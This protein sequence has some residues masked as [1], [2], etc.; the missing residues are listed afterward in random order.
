M[1]THTASR[2]TPGANVRGTTLG[3]EISDFLIEFSIGVHR[4]SMYPLDHPS[5]VP[6]AGNVLERLRPMLDQRAQVSLGVAKRQLII[7]G[8]ATTDR[9]PVLTDLA[10]RLHSHQ[11]GA[12]TF[13][14]D[15]TLAGMEGLLRALA[16]DTDQDGDPIGL[17]PKSRIP[18]WP[19]VKLIPVGYEDL[20]LVGS[21]EGPQESRG[22][23]MRLWLGLAQAA[24]ANADEPQDSGTPPGGDEVAERINRRKQE[25]AYD[26]V[27]VGYLL[28]LSDQLARAELDAAASVRG[29]VSK[30]IAALDDEALERILE[31]GGDLAQRRRFVEN[32]TKGLDT[33]AALRILTSASEAA[34]QGISGQMVRLLSKLARQ[35]REGTPPVRPVASRDFDQKVGEL[36]SDWSLDSPNP[37]AY[38]RILD[39]LS[40]ES[41]LLEPRDEHTRR[42]AL[43]LVEMAL[44]VDAYGP[45]I[46]SALDELLA[47]G[48]FVQ[49]V[50][51]IEGAHVTRTGRKIKERLSDP[52]QVERLAELTELHPTSLE[53][54]IGLVGAERAIEPLLIVLAE[55]ESRGTRRTVFDGLAG[56]GEPVARHLQPL[57]QDERWYVLRNVLALV[58]ALPTRPAG[59]TAE[60]FIS[61]EDAR[62]R[63]E[64]IPLA[65]T[66]PGLREK[67]LS[68]ALRDPDE[69]TVRIALGDLVAGL[70]EAV[71]PIVRSQLLHGGRWPAELEVVA[72]R[73]LAGA[74]GRQGLTTLIELATSG[75]GLFGRPK[76]RSASKP[77]VTALEVMAG[78]WPDDPE[79]A[80]LLKA[81]RKSRSAVIRR[82]VSGEG[83]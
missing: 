57:L 47:D 72:I 43:S 13:D 23:A 22:E 38:V 48:S 51:R 44:E 66:E 78:T 76:L 58:A 29:R 26:Q 56:L 25:K 50:P 80:R 36:L 28:Q 20:E 2:S 6:A 60:P 21:E 32:A 39:D 8:V 46:E 7:D 79:V 15:L 24:A 19:G 69:R 12:I 9:N 67:T 10:R 71:V 41:P 49:I 73:A 59:F 17:R 55:A 34:G 4:Y 16:L 63:R 53:A 33:A 52:D 65:L 81:A 3:K 83:A 45:M 64:A 82:A 31:M 37:D 18:S 61:H 68:H 74:P 1:T 11:I 35:A 54:L 5:L 75:R 14:S 70:P 40:G 42:S 77:V 27:I 62:V 30:L